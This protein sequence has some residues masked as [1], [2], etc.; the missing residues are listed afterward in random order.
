[1]AVF[2]AGSW[3]A[4][5]SCNAG[6][7]PIKT[8]P[9]I[10]RF[11]NVLVVILDGVVVKSSLNTQSED[12]D[13]SKQVNSSVKILGNQTVDVF[14]IN[15]INSLKYNGLFYVWTKVDGVFYK[16]RLDLNESRKKLIFSKRITFKDKGRWQVLLIDRYGKLYN[17]LNFVLAVE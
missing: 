3:L 9:P 17:K 2:I 15:K 11:K 1:M 8:Q 14:W 12:G 6:K 4:A 16:K 5:I 13:L 7:N 10:F